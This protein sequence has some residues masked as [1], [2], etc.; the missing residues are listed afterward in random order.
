M[1]K[2]F[3]AA[4]PFW[5]TLI[6]TIS[7]ETL[8]RELFIN[9]MGYCDDDNQREADESLNQKDYQELGSTV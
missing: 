4:I 7:N 9:G 5:I 2:G 1:I 6:S 3:D 8:L